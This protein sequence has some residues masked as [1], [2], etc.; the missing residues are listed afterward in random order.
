[1]E[2]DASTIRPAPHLTLFRRRRRAPPTGRL[3]APTLPYP[4]YPYRP[5]GLPP[6]HQ[7]PAPAPMAQGH[8][9]RAQGIVDGLDAAVR[10]IVARAHADGGKAGNALAG[11]CLGQGVCGAPAP[12]G[13]GGDQREALLA[14]LETGLLRMREEQTR[15]AK[16][17]HEVHA[18]KAR[19]HA[20]K[21]GGPEHPAAQEIEELHLRAEELERENVGLRLARLRSESSAEP[22]TSSAH[23]TAHLDALHLALETAHSRTAEARARGDKLHREANRLKHAEE[24]HHATIEIKEKE[25]KDAMMRQVVGRMMS[26]SVAAA[27]DRW[28]EALSASEEQVPSPSPL[29]RSLMDAGA[30]RALADAIDK[31]ASEAGV[32]VDD[33]GALEQALRGLPQCIASFQPARSHADHERTPF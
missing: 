6:T 7:P 2:Q 27:F 23:G 4:A 3:P 14:A 1:M 20:L 18:M 21:H 29:V 11:S 32:D 26:R 30:V 28:H 12:G 33:A 5:T 19:M 31:F 25:R 17:Q 10:Q 9:L 16:I 8:I 15:T 22:V 24:E 13:P